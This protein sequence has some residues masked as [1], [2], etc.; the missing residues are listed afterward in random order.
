MANLIYHQLLYSYHIQHVQGLKN[1]DF[2]PRLPFCQ[3]IQQQSD[4]DR[5][6]LNNVLF[7]HEAGFNRDGIF[8]FHN[9]HA[10]AVVNPNGVKQARHQQ[11]FSFNVWVEIL[12]DSLYQ[13]SPA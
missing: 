6:F 8:N 7:T 1:T 10:W 3:Q 13:R 12:G 2:P 4:L 5:Q 11:S 9:Y